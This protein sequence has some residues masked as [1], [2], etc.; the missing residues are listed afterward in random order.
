MQKSER[1]E[2]MF[3]PKES[4]EQQEK[5]IQK[6][7]RQLKKEMEEKIRQIK[8]SYEESFQLL[9]N[10]K[11]RMEEEKKQHFASYIQHKIGEEYEILQANW[12]PDWGEY[13]FYV[14]LA[15]GEL[16]MEIINSVPDD[17]RTG[18]EEAKWHLQYRIYQMKGERE[19]PELWKVHLKVGELA[20]RIKDDLVEE[21]SCRLLSL[22]NDELI[23]VT[24]QS[25]KLACLTEEEYEIWMMYMQGK[26]YKE[27][28]IQTGMSPSEL[29]NFVQRM[30]RNLA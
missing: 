29:D 16:Q 7:E 15:C 21:P 5:E 13:G 9:E 28:R 11:Q 3:L 17:L 22:F 30:R 27:L 1:S 4:H 12:K 14:L 20:Q 18:F 6:K 10:E 26:T 24:N 23:L 19:H 25:P 2:P 8:Q